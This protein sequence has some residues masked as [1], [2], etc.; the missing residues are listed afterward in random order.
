V[1]MNHRWLLLIALAGLTA[2]TLPASLS[3]KKL[4]D[5]K[6]ILG[7]LPANLAGLDLYSPRPTLKHY[8]NADEDSSIIVS[9][10][11]SNDL[12]TSLGKAVSIA[13]MQILSSDHKNFRAMKSSKYPGGSGWYVHFSYGLDDLCENFSQQWLFDV[14]D[15]RIDAEACAASEDEAKLQRSQV[16]KYVFG[17]V[18]LSPWLAK[19]EK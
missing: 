18:K 5:A 10:P 15:I 1:T 13:K 7:G 6:A 3:A 8:Q 17:K 2:A 14:D 12:R 9:I 16:E 11:K 4:V 19:D